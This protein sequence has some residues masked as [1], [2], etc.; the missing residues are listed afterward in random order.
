MT[1]AKRSGSLALAALLLGAGL[2]CQA[3]QLTP[4]QVLA[5]RQAQTR[6]FETPMDTVFKACMTYLQ[7]NGFQIRQASKESGILTAFKAQ[8]LSGGNRF[9]GALIV[10]REAKGGDHFDVTFTFDAVDPANTVVRCNISH[11]ESN[12][13]GAQMSAAAVT[14]LAQYKSLLD[15]LSLEVHRRDLARTMRDGN[16]QP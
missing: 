11:G 3:P 9:L 15:G 13:A 10:G 14:D 8:N 12:L 4:D 2:A 6:A 16:Q 1:H 5:L 7:D